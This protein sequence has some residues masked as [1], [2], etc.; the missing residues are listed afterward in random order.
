MMKFSHQ[1]GTRLTSGPERYNAGPPTFPS[2]GAQI[3]GT[4]VGG[5]VKYAY[6]PLG[7][8]GQPTG[9]QFTRSYRVAAIGEVPPALVDQSGEAQR[10]ILPPG[11]TRQVLA[12]YFY[13]WIGLRLAR[14]TAGIPALLGLAALVVAGNL[15][16]SVPAAA[17]V[18]TGAAAALRTE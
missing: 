8:D 11:A 3:F 1:S 15:L 16:A 10:A 9:R 2:Q 7:A 13:A 12:E 14:G 6:Q 17:A 4:G 18:R 5:T